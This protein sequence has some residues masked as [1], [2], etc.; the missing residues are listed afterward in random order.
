[1]IGAKVFRK[2]STS[3]L[4]NSGLTCKINIISTHCSYQGMY[5]RRGFKRKFGSKKSSYSFP[6]K[7]RYSTK[8]GRRGTYGS[9]RSGR[10]LL[11]SSKS[12]NAPGGAQ[13]A[14]LLVQR[15]PSLWPDRLRLPLRF[16]IASTVTLTMGAPQ[17]VVIEANN[18]Y[19][20]SGAI[21]ATQPYGFDQLISLYSRF[22]VFGS[23]IQ[24]K[25]TIDQTGTASTLNSI[26][27]GSIWAD[28]TTST[29][30]S[31]VT[32]GDTAPTGKPFLTRVDLP[33]DPEGCF[34]VRNYATSAK[35]FGVPA[36]RILNDGVFHGVSNASPSRV[37]YWNILLYGQNASG[38]L[39]NQVC[40]LKLDL[41][42]YTELY[43]LVYNSSS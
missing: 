20:P 43:S 18:I 39:L 28:T 6:K 27:R 21:G 9:S 33:S 10:S 41:V 31:D 24:A 29:F 12:W 11:P 19:D 1:M 35:M 32:V 40:G 25:L 7:R 5:G 34:T 2:F 36:S 42:F 23:A 8:R 30:T 22:I 16:S 38:A 3:C 37:W 14:H 17:Q 4:H 26:I 13:N 15:G